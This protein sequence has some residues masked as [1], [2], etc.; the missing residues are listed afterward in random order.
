M[1]N[2]TDLVG[3]VARETGLSKADAGRAVE[4]ALAFIASE[5]AAGRPVTLAGFGRFAL[6]TRPARQGRN[7]RTG[8]AIEIAASSALAFRPARARPQ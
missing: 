3:A 2:R 5:A 1:S 8:A 7:P 6:R 4:A